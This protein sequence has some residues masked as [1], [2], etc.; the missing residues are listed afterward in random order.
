[1]ILA[2][3]SIWIDHLRS[4]VSRLA[5]VVDA[6]EPLMHPMVIG[7]L[8]CGNL[9]NREQRLGDWQRFPMI[10]EAE[11]E[12]VLSVIESRRLMGRGIGFIDAHLLCAVL[13]HANALL[14]TRDGSLHRVAKD[15]GVAFSEDAWRKD[16]WPKDRSGDT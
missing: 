4:P 15:L 10:P 8:A 3:T 9:S 14:W 13:N 6:N 16:G 1:M 5:E 7:E 11:N 2:D 12:D